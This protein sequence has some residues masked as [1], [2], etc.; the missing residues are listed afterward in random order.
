MLLRMS[1]PARNR[2]RSPLNPWGE[3]DWKSKVNYRGSRILVNWENCSTWPVEIF[4]MRATGSAWSSVQ[5]ELQEPYTALP[6]QFEMADLVELLKAEMSE[7]GAC[8]PSI[9]T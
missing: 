6:V 8:R 5:T 1:K 7:R 2:G 4:V 9:K 3:A